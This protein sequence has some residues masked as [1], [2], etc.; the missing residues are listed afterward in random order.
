MDHRIGITLVVALATATGCDRKSNAPPPPEQKVATDRP[1]TQELTQTPFTPLSLLTAGMPATIQVPKGWALTKE[2]NPAYLRIQGYTPTDVADIAFVP[3]VTKTA[4]KKDDL[5]ET[6][7]RQMAADPLTASIPAV[8]ESNGALVI[9][10][11]DL[12]VLPPPGALS[13][14]APAATRPAESAISP[15]SPVEWS[16]MLCVPNQDQ[17]SFYQIRL[18]GLTRAQFTADRDF[19]QKIMG[20]LNYDPPSARP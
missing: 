11:V 5:V 15:N 18:V 19:L 17:F 12:S 16:V 10:S 8:R 6:V 7:R 4:I 3:L 13:A 14:T 9:E 20:S 2:I 1:T